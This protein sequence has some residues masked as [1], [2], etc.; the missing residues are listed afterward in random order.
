MNTN[1]VKRYCQSCKKFY[2]I[3]KTAEG[4]EYLTKT[5]EKTD[6]HYCENSDKKCLICEKYSC[7]H[8]TKKNSFILIYHEKRPNKHRQ[9]QYIRRGGSPSEMG[10]DD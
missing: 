1:L 10:S 5:E 9:R 8:L 7:E 6:F 3:Q 2:Y 4:K